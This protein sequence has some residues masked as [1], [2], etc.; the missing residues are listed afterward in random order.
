MFLFC[1]ILDATFDDVLPLALPRMPAAWEGIV[2][3][4]IRDYINLNIAEQM[5]QYPGPILMIRR[6]EDEIICTE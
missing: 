4:A 5:Y 1:Q 2:K 6:T 3:L